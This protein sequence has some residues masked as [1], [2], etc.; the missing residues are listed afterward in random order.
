MNPVELKKKISYSKWKCRRKEKNEKKKGNGCSL[1]DLKQFLDL[2]FMPIEHFN[3]DIGKIESMLF[4]VNSGECSYQ[5][6]RTV[7]NERF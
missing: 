4:K 3:T 6:L 5:E 2:N 7:L 1:E